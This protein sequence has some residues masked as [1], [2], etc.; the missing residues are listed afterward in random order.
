MSHHI[1]GDTVGTRLINAEG[2]QHV[3]KQL[4]DH[5]SDLMTAHY[6]RICQQTARRNWEQA[7][8]VN[9]AGQPVTVEPE[10]PHAD[11]LWMKESLARAKMALPNGFC[12]LPLQKSYA[13]ANALF[14]LPVVRHDGGVPARSPPAAHRD[15]AADQQ[16]RRG[17]ARPARR[18]QPHRGKESDAHHHR[19]QQAGTSCGSA[20]DGGG[21]ACDDRPAD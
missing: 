12:T 20:T 9:I 14:D 13:H 4:M 3:V 17:R 21:C 6:A 8:R 2:P 16:G 5:T 11:A 10:S 15:P 1:N 7:H 19:P 18:K